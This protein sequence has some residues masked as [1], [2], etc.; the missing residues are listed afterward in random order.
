[1]QEVLAL[2]FVRRHLL[3]YEQHVKQ[4]VQ[5]SQRSSFM[6]SV[7]A[8]LPMSMQVSLKMPPYTH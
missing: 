2:E 3:A 1:M 4:H 7:H 5:V 8:H 6:A